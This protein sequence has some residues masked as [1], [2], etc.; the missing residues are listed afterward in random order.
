MSDPRLELG[1]PV[2]PNRRII[3]SESENELNFLQP[4]LGGRG[5]LRLPENLSCDGKVESLI[6]GEVL[7]DE[8]IVS[9]TKV[10]DAVGTI[11]ANVNLA[12]RVG[13]LV[14]NVHWLVADVS[15][16]S[17]SGRPYAD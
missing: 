16:D 9:A 13:D 8:V 14:D 2:I 12:I 7:R 5:C 17:L 10:V 3:G 1:P 6:P 4:D 15:I 11:L